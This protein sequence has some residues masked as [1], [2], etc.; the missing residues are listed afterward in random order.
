MAAQTYVVFH[1][2]ADDSYMNSTAN[3]R[4]AEAGAEF[5]DIFFESATSTSSTGGAYDVVRVT[6]TNGEEDRAIEQIA[7]A[8]GGI[9]AGGFVVIADDVNSVYAGQDILSCGAITLASQAVKRVVMA[10]TADYTMTAADSGKIVLVNPASTTAI[11]LPTLAAA[12]TG[13]NCK[14]V[15]TEDTDGSDGGM[16]GI[17][18]ID[19]GSGNDVVGILVSNED[20][21]AGD[22][23]VNND[24]FINFTADASPGDMVDIFTDGSRWYCHG[25]VKAAGSDVKFH[26]DAA[27]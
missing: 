18:N 24:D 1:T 17:V 2:A 10:K 22:Y 12:L 26:T 25:I 11:T 14:V 23:A 4:G 20:S 3:F 7:S 6:C 16:G 15:V 8:M 19:F 27:S 5:I 13:W 9:K 21:T